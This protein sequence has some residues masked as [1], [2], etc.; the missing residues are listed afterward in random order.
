MPS[1]LLHGAVGPAEPLTLVATEG[2]RDQAS[3]EGD[4]DI[5]GA[6]A[7]SV[8]ADGQLGVLGNAPLGPSPTLLQR[9]S[10]DQAHRPEDHRRGALVLTHEHGMEERPV[11]PI[12]EPK[13]DAF[14]PG[15]VVVGSLDEPHPGIGE[16][17]D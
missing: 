15:A 13:V 1:Q 2:R 5:D 6:V 11:F 4:G 9:R 3:P 16:V 8:D 17:A 7:Q 10:T 14:L 12:A